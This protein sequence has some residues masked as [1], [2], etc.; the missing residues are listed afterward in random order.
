MV[1]ALSSA[2]VEGGVIVAAGILIF[3]FGF[4]IRIGIEGAIESIEVGLIELN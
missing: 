3:G 2:G 1:E 4:S